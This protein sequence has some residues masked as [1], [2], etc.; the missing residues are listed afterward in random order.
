MLQ[1]AGLLNSWLDRL[2]VL[3]V[4]TTGALTFFALQYVGP[5]AFAPSDP[6]APPAE[7][8]PPVSAPAPEAAPVAEPVRDP[9]AG[10]AQAGMNALQAGDAAAAIRWFERAVQAS[11]LNAAWRRGL[12]DAYRVSGDSLRASEAGM[13]ALELETEAPQLEPA[14][15]PAPAS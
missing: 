1:G 13:R 9:G 8:T 11:P 5:G 2:L 6:A 4:F 7:A 10:F 12:A 15:T 3:L 14:P